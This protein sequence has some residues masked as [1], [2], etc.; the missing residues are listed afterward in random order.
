M[1]YIVEV[2][3]VKK[4]FKEVHAV[5]GVNLTIK[6]GEFVGLLGPNG[7]GKTTMVEMIEG[8]Q[9][10]D[11]G[12]I[13]IAGK[14]WKNNS[15]ELHQLIGL[16]LQETHFIDRL[17][18]FE[19]GQLFASFYKLGTDRVNEVIELVGLQEKR[20][21]YVTTLSGGQRQRLA[22]G[23][24]LL[25]KPSV[26]LL[27]EPTTGL[28]P[29]ARREIWMILKK[30]K[31]EQNTSLILTTHYMEE[32]EFLCDRIVMMDQGTILADGPLDQLL[33]DFDNARNLDEL[34][35]NMTGRHLYE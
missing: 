8:L 12:E 3:N 5:K 20:K 16:S 1:E 35:I 13:K 32:A 9:H 27:D 23:I 17:S 18:V 4:S 22:L 2:S 21:A 34:F 30:L 28:D 26:L 33:R 10:P 31:D 29:N 24:A 19:T 11:S 25:N 14:T 7:A 15:K 6:P